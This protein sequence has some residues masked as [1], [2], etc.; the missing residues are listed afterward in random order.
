MPEAPVAM[1]KPRSGHPIKVPKVIQEKMKRKVQTTPTITA[2]QLKKTIPE[3][4]DTSVRTIQHQCLKVLKL[5]SRKMANKPL[6]TERMRR[7]RLDFARRYQH[8][9]VEEWRKVMFSDESHFELRFGQQGWRC[10]RAKGSDRCDPKFTRKRVKHPPKVMAW[11]CFSWRGRGGLEFL[12]PGEMMNGERYRRVLDE[13][14]EI[15]M[16]QHGTTHF[17]QDGA[18]CHTSKI[19]KAWFQERPQIQLIK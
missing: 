4:A 19:A 1:R 16:H 17:L 10:R 7:D 8:W 2:R 13:K 6:L 11:G 12:K 9:G 3:L 5:P 18:P 15:F 14:L